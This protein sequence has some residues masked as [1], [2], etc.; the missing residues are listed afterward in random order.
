MAQSK[1]K[2][3]GSS[4]MDKVIKTA[5]GKKDKPKIGRPATLPGVK[6]IRTTVALTRD[7]ST[8]L[9]IATIHEQNKRKDKVDASLLVEEAL[10]AWLKKKKY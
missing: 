6:R 1:K 4:I 7:V 8:R 10:E 3:T 5:K 9:K 2:K